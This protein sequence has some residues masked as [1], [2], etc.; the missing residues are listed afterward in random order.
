MREVTESREG[1]MPDPG[2]AEKSGMERRLR[3]VKNQD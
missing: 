3:E 1:Q 2:R